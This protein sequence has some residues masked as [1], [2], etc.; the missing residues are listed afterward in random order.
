[1]AHI[2][3]DL[4]QE[5]STSTGTGTFTLAG[6]RGPGR[7]FSSVCSVSDT[8]YYCITN[9]S[10]SEFEVGLGTL[11]SST[12][13]SRFPLASSNSNALV[14]FSVG[15]KHVDLFFSATRIAALAGDGLQ[16]TSIGG[17]GIDVSDFAGTGLEDDGSENLR[18]AASAAG[19]GLTGGAG[20]PLA[21][22]SG[23]GITVSA[24]AVNWDG[25]GIY[26]PD[27]S[28]FVKNAVGIAPLTT[29]S[30]IG[31]A[32]D[33]GGQGAGFSYQRAA[34]A[35]AIA[36]SQNSNDS[37][38]A[39]I[40]DNDAA[41]N[42]RTNLNFVTTTD[43][44]LSVTDDAANDELEISASLA[45]PVVTTEATG[46][47]F[48]DHALP[49]NTGI[50]SFTATSTI[51]SVAGGAEGR[52]LTIRNDAAAGSGVVITIQQFT[53]GASGNRFLLAKAVNMVLHPG[54]SSK[55][56]YMSS[57]WRSTELG[58][59]LVRKASSGLGTARGRLNILDGTGITTTI[60]D[61]SANDELDISIAANAASDTAVGVIE[62]A[63]Q[64]EMET[65][66][67]VTRAVT[68]GR[69]H[70]H[71]S[72]IKC[73]GFTTGAGTPV[74]HANSYNVTSITDTATGRLTVTIGNDFSSA[75]WCGVCT[76][77]CT[78]NANRMA[79]LVSKAAG[80]VILEA[81]SATTTLA[82]P[83]VGWDWQFMG[84]L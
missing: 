62:L 23:T 35:G 72:A 83:G 4:V 19:D 28:T 9:T 66:T 11:A 34:V 79:C 25:V 10:F 78:T 26:E 52:K 65:G 74:L 42:N 53:G 12:T 43:V 33:T 60:T 76:P 81:S 77:T 64:S 44:V 63:I 3:A 17:L 49:A 80:S 16:E 75:N 30:I 48:T 8:F 29:T 14:N 54:D 24:N 6:A 50:W 37:T 84:D 73:F 47:T 68:P 2:T 56:D 36:M 71:P 67:D 22:G 5:F 57:R 55:F 20:S 40:K 7:T 70:F 18:I 13:F 39:G 58:Y 46:G 59:Q 32:V 1:M 69:Q 21:V 41:E 31:D 15:T 45:A 38:F 82:D 61:D 51:S 27:V